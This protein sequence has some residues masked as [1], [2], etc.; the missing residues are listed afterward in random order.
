MVTSEIQIISNHCIKYK[1]DGLIPFVLCLTGKIFGSSKDFIILRTSCKRSLTFST[2]AVKCDVINKI[3]DPNRE[4]EIATAPFVRNAV[5]G[6]VLK[7]DSS[8]TKIKKK[9]N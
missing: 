8:D 2:C 6:L 3:D 9:K 5:P 4:K 7:L 1:I